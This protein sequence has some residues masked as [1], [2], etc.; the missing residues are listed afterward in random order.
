[1]YTRVKDDALT[2]RYTALISI[3]FV[4]YQVYAFAPRRIAIG[5]T[6]SGIFGPPIS[7]DFDNTCPY[8]TAI[9]GTPFSAPLNL[10]RSRFPRAYRGTKVATTSRSQS[11]WMTNSHHSPLPFTTLIFGRRTYISRIP[12]RHTISEDGLGYGCVDHGQFS[13][14]T[15]AD[16][17]PQQRGPAEEPRDVRRPKL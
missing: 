4:S 7:D 17:S 11:S 10:S 9:S 16:Q 3:H 2:E 14:C 5:V 15:R 12:E 13:G 1:M 6:S 8:G